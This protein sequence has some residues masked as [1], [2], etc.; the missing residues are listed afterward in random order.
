MATGPSVQHL[1]PIPSS[2][3]QGI[4][5]LLFKSK[6]PTGQSSPPSRP[7][8]IQAKPSGERPAVVKPQQPVVPPKVATKFA[9]QANVQ[10]PNVEV[11]PA[12]TPKLNKPVSS[13][14][15]KVAPGK[16]KRIRPFLFL[17]W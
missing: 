3:V 9:T 2:R 7:L 17:G 8:V 4:T 11:K 10:K 14:N 5:H 12:V 1:H 15:E 13:A 16:G 6:Q